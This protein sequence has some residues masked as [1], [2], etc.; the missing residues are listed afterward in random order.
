MRMSAAVLAVLFAASSALAETIVLAGATIH[1]V[2]GPDIP[3]GMVVIRD[4]KIAAVGAAAA[5]AEVPAGAKT[6]DVKGRH[7]YPSLFPAITDL[8]LVEISSVRATVDTTE[9]GEIN[10]EARADFAMNFDSELL[11]V[12]RSAGILVAGIAP[13]GGIV[14]GSLA[15]MKLDGWTREDATLKA[16]A[17]IIVRWPDLTIDHSPQAR[18]SVRIQEKRR[19]ENL[20]KLKDVFAGARGYAAAR[21]AEGKSGIPRHDFDPRLEALLPAI[22]G[23]IPVLV[24]AQRVKQIRDALA[25][26]KEE[27]LKIVLAGAKDGWRIAGEIAA[28]GVPVIVEQPIELPT[29][30]DEPYDVNF[31]NA[32]A[33]A[34]AGVRVAFTDGSNA[35]NARNLS[36][37]CAS[38]VAFGF[39]REKAVAAMTLEPAKMLGVAD[40]IGSLEPGKDATLI[41]TDGDILDLRTHVLAAYLDGRPLDLSDKQ[42]RLYERY[43][44]RPKPSSR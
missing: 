28:A 4:G 12:A 19:D 31:A 25:W 1:P 24:V 37:Q 9:L 34:R 6:V 44:N 5:A 16:P 32:G 14:S 27:N 26:A 41:V 18:F 21:G 17:A 8:G 2:S 23:K 42:K 10:P 11:P 30:A 3:D 13:S 40:R 38:A 22:D 33:L 35:S 15:A 43:R 36:H 7:V 20:Q 39:P 29:R